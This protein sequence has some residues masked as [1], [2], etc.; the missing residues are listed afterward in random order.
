MYLKFL[1]DHNDHKAD[2]VV[3]VSA[4]Y[5]EFLI[6]GGFAKPAD[7]PEEPKEAPKPKKK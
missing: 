7:K 4:G 2:E 3:F 6:D 1:K 5:A